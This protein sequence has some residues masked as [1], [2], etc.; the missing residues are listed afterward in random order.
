MQPSF[1]LGWLFSSVLA[2][3]PVVEHRSK[4]RTR[5]SDSRLRFPFLL[6]ILRRSGLANARNAAII[7]GHCAVVRSCGRA[8]VR[9]CGRVVVRLCG[10]VRESVSEDSCESTHVVY[11]HNQIDRRKA[12]KSI[13]TR[14]LDEDSETWPRQRGNGAHVRRCF[15]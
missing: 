13:T 1:W 5:V 6:V 10:R 7:R 8:V 3:V 14:D 4:G 11:N 2:H 12:P 9:S 15:Y